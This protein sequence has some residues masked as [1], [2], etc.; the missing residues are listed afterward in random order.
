MLIENQYVQQ[1]WNRKNK[2]FY[3]DKGYSFTKIKDTLWVNAEDLTPASKT[4]VYVECDYC[5]RIIEKPY[6]NYIIEISKEIPKCACSKCAGK[7]L[8]EAKTLKFK[9]KYDKFLKLCEE[10]NLKPISTEYIDSNTK[11]RYEC[12]IHGIQEGKMDYLQNIGCG[13]CRT[14]EWKIPHD[15]KILESFKND[16]IQKGYESLATIDDYKD[17]ESLLPYKCPI[18]GLKYISYNNLHYGDRGCNE[19]GYK[20]RGDGLKLNIETVR[21]KI[22]EKNH[23]EWLNDTEY[24]NAITRNLE[25]LCGNCGRTFIVSLNNY[26]KNITGK[27]P[28]CN[29]VSIGE[30]LISI[31]LDKH[32]IP[33]ERGKRYSDCKDKRTLPFDFYL[34]TYNMIIEFDGPHHFMEVWGIEH[35]EMTKRHDKMKNE[36]CKN[37]NIPILRI[38]YYQGKQLDKILTEELHL[39]KFIKIKPQFK[40]KKLNK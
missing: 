6:G 24:I 22:E 27:C 35:F 16:C 28:D 30:Y 1:N 9:S 17:M 32:E 37:N 10:R 14:D 40:C 18:H 25:I 19:C 33:Y 36:Y 34:P 39:Q 3:I 11:L 26:D 38:P 5:H 8:A 13:Q 20:I 31:F 29:E 7:K 23:N 21:N 2:S 15:E 4:K 12:P